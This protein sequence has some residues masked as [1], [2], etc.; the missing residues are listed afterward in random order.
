M[1]IVSAP[2]RKGGKYTPC[3]TMASMGRWSVIPGC[4]GWWKNAALIADLPGE[5]ARGALV[6]VRSDNRKTPRLDERAKHGN[7]R[8]ARSSRA[9]QQ[10]QDRNRPRP[11]PGGKIV[12]A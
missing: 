4:G 7:D 10:N 5:L 9:V 3:L 8:L 1:P 11:R 6:R 12:R 2:R